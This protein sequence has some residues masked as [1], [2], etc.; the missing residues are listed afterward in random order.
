MKTIM[1]CAAIAM[2][3]VSAT[4]APAAD[5]FPSAQEVRIRLLMAEYREMA[6]NAVARI[7]AASES[8]R[9]LPDTYFYFAGWI[10]ATGAIP[11]LVRDV[12][13]PCL[14]PEAKRLADA[15]D[16]W[17]KAKKEPGG[18]AWSPV[19]SEKTGW[20]RYPP[21]PA[22]GALSLMSIP[23]ESFTNMI[24]EARFRGRAA[25]LIAW[26]ATARHGESFRSAANDL[27]KTGD[28]VWVRVS[29]FLDDYRRW[30]WR[31]S[32]RWNKPHF[33]ADE[34]RRFSRISENLRD[35]ATDASAAGDGRVLELAEAALAEIGRQ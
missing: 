29:E 33:P 24:G 17:R 4:A 14:D 9:P 16:A 2:S 32:E 30:I 13:R 19:S 8:G 7:E 34:T 18:A 5:T 23:L 25:E 22:A 6:S 28:P 12:E 20:Y 21:T 26:A 1:T 27:A 10:N 3:F 11:C 31:V 15:V 35:I